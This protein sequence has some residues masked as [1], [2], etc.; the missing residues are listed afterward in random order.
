MKQNKTNVLMLASMVMCGNAMAEDVQLDGHW[1][2][3]GGAALSG[4]TRSQSLSLNADAARATADDK[5]SLYGQ[6]LGSRATANGVT[7]TSANQWKAGTRYDRNIS[8]DVFSF[9]GLDFNHDQIQQLSLRSVV[10]GGLG[11]HLIKTPANKW[12]IFG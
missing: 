8:S 1:R 9:A 7:T 2:G 11:Y 10:S 3:S 4:N 5:L 12:D 6:I